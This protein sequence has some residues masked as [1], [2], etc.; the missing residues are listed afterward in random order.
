MHILYLIHDAKVAL[1]FCNW[2]ANVGGEGENRMSWGGEKSLAKV[3]NRSEG[4]KN[5]RKKG[6][7]SHF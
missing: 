7:K 6:R 1:L 3:E 5:G 2:V 4:G